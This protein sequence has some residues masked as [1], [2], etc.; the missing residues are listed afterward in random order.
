[1]KK[2]LIAAGIAAVIAAPA[3]MADTTVYGKVRMS[4]DKTDGTTAGAPDK[5]NFSDRASRFGFKGTEDLGNGLSAFYKMEFGV[6]TLGGNTGVANATSVTETLTVVS[7]N[8]QGG[9]A[10]VVATVTE[11]TDTKV[12]VGTWLSQRNMVVGLKGSFGSVF[13]GRHD[14]PYKLAGSADLFGDTIADSQGKSTGIIGRN[15]FD[16]RIAGTV[17]YVTPTVNG[18]HAAVAIVP[19]NDI[20]GGAGN[21]ADGLADSY[22]AALIYGNGPLTAALAYEKH[23]KN[24]GDATSQTTADDAYVADRSATKLNLGYTMGDLKLGAT[25]E[26]ADDLQKTAGT[27]M[28]EDDAYLLSAAYTMGNNVLMAQYG[29]FDDKSSATTG[30]VERTALG[31]KHKFSKQSDLMMIYKKDENQGSA[32]DTTDFSLQLNHSF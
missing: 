2:T 16:Q 31:L 8:A 10:T 5:W 11:S 21:T 22:S 24:Y 23:D 28:K 17:A 32:V 4:L 26:K 25:Y 6:N 19:G 3:A 12:S 29:E 7:G 27:A 30:D 20:S 14:T 15:N 1:M 18:L 9:P 13:A